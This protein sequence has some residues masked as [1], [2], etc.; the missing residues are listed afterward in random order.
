M[1]S[2]LLFLDFTARLSPLSTPISSKL[3]LPW[4]PRFLSTQ[5][6][7]YISKFLM[8]YPTSFLNLLYVLFTPNIKHPIFK[9][10]TQICSLDSHYHI[11]LLS[12]S[13]LG[14]LAGTNIRRVYN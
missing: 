11:L 12:K 3:L 1:H 2:S 10:N 8:T 6:N 4:F 13:S 7:T 14:S 9:K 5:P